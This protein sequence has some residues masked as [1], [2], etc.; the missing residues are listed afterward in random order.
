MVVESQ[1]E[2]ALRGC[3]KVHSTLLQTGHKS[4]GSGA[5]V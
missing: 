1:I 3:V 2:A 5:K 4:L